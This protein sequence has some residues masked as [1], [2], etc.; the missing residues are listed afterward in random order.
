M[1]AQAH[2]GF[3]SIVQNVVVVW[4]MLR[5]GKDCTWSRPALHAK[6]PRDLQLRAGHPPRRGQRGPAHAY[7]KA[8]TREA[9]RRRAADGEAAHER[10]TRGWQPRGPRRARMGAAREERP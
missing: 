9:E 1:T 7:S 2:A 8:G 10:L 6:K 3:C 4:H 5:E